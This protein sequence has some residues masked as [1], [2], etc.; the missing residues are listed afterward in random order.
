MVKDMCIFM[1]AYV[2]VLKL[3]QWLARSFEIA[4]S[5]GFLPDWRLD[6]IERDFTSCWSSELNRPISKS[7]VT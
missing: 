1:S 2:R 4:F 6:R 5:R 3:I 7:I